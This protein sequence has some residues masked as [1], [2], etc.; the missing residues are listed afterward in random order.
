MD[1]RHGKTTWGPILEVPG[2]Y[3]A[4]EAVLFSIPDESFKRFKNCTIALSA[5][6]TKWTS[7]EVRTHLTFLLLSS[8]FLETLIS[9]Y[10]FGPVKL[11]VLSRNGPLGP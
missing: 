1:L 10:D 6:E 9:K 11:P 8:T 7:L 2:N 4:R 5:K 3:R